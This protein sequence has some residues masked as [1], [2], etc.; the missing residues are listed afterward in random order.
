MRTLVKTVNKN[1]WIKRLWI[2]DRIITLGIELMHDSG[3]GAR[4]E[5]LWMASPL[6]HQGYHEF[7]L[8]VGIE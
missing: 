5:A 2:A 4:I 7:G 3:Y 6:N 1:W 8:P